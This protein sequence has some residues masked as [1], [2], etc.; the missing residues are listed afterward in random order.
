MTNHS[1]VGIVVLNWNG[2]EDTL[3]CLA[4]VFAIEYPNF[5]VIV[6]DNGSVDGSVPAI[7]KEFPQAVVLETGRNLGYA[8]G[9]NVGIEAALQRG[10]EFVFILNNDAVVDPAVLKAFMEAAGA[11]PDG[12]AFAAKIYYKSAPRLLWYAGGLWQEESGTFAHIG[13]HATDTCSCFE[14]LTE[15]D[16]ACG[17]AMLLRASAI[18]NVGIFD[19]MFFLTFEEPDWCFR[20]KKK[21]YRSIFVPGAKVWHKVSVSFGGENSPL[22]IYFYTRNRLLWAERHLGLN[23]RLKVWRSTVREMLP[24]W[25]EHRPGESHRFKKRYWRSIAWVK[26]LRCDWPNPTRRAMRRAVMDYVFRSFG[27]CPQAVRHA[28]RAAPR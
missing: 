28:N 5:E 16:Y 12:G 2:R 20:A 25:E 22:F 17:C 19:P 6:V 11:Y 3:E 15:T 1:L 4:S 23:G 8:G 18:R 13:M 24:P 21:G 26:R 10:A 9:N 14:G 27:D 7:K